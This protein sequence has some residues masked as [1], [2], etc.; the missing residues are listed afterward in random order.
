[1]LIG[2]SGRTGVV[3]SSNIGHRRCIAFQRREKNGNFAVRSAVFFVKVSAIYTIA[4]WWSRT[5]SVLIAT[6]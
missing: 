6:V 5:A 4:Q 3:K 2:A 1:M